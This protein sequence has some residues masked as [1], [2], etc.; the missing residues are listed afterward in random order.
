M[1]VDQ[2]PS[3]LRTDAVTNT[4]LKIVHKMPSEDDRKTVGACMGLNS[5]Q[6]DLIAALEIGQA[7][8]ASEQDDGAS[9]VKVYRNEN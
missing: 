7:I 3:Q 4:N 2:Q 6:T 8:V 1:I 9:W 5:E